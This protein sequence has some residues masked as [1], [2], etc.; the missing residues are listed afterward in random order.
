MASKPG[1]ISHDPFSALLPAQTPGTLGVRDRADPNA[2]A[3]PGN[4]PGST[5][6][7]DGAAHG[8]TGRSALPVRML[9]SMI[10]AASPDAGLLKTGLFA[11]H[12]GT[13]TIAES[14]NICAEPIKGP[15][16]KAVYV[17]NVKALATAVGD[18]ENK[19]TVLGILVHGDAGGRLWIGNDELN[20]ATI[21]DYK[22]DFDA[23][24]K[25]LAKDATVF[26]YGC[27]SGLGKDGS[28]LL[29]ELS[30]LLPG[31]K[32]VGFNVV[33]SVKPTSMRKEGEG[34]FG[35]GGHSCY[36]PEVWTTSVRS[37]L[38]INAP[39]ASAYV[40]AAT[41]DAPQAKVA[42]DGKIVKWP[43]DESPKNDDA[44]K[45]DVLKKWKRKQ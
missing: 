19:V 33:N 3:Q 39:G 43:S 36:D 42:Q 14:K 30:R 23:L 20:P 12:I 45:Q 40:N 22:S 28:V 27:V 6:I 44:E 24:S 34:Y 38:V 7:N 11:Y 5:G 15:Y 2:N 31:R 25:N 10:L 16:R 4:T 26:A 8:A 1:P 9:S 37:A 29:K 32:I 21:E 13:G 41:E 17:E 18:A 35:L